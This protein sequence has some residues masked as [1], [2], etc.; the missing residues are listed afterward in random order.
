MGIANFNSIK[1]TRDTKRGITPASLKYLQDT[2]T[3]EQNLI[4][5]FKLNNRIIK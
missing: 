5:V 4:Q 1:F 3:F 2:L